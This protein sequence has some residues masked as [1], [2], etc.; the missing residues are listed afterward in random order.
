MGSTNG[1]W[2][3]TAVITSKGEG[4]DSIRLGRSHLDHATMVD[5]AVVLNHSGRTKR[6]KRNCGAKIPPRHQL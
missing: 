2:R 6:R 4:D 5:C 3:V 1:Y